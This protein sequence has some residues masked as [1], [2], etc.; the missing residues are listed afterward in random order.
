M[1]EIRYFQINAE[2]KMM[3]CIDAD[4]LFDHFDQRETM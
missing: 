1:T 4:A 3:V 2:N